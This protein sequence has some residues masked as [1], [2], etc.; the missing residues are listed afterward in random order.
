MVS[1]NLFNFIVSEETFNTP[2][3][4]DNVIKGKIT[5]MIK[6]IIPPDKNATAGLYIDAET[7]PPEATIKVNI[8]GD[9]I[10]L[11]LDSKII[12]FFALLKI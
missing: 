4:A 1:E 10:S 3:I 9:I 7:L 8:M 2:K 11:K 6:L 5:E 12:V